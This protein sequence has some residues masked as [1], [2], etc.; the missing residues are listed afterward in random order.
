MISPYTRPSSLNPSREVS[1][2]PGN[3]FHTQETFSQ[4][5]PPFTPQEDAIASFVNEEVGEMKK[6]TAFKA[7]ALGANEVRNNVARELSRTGGLR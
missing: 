3:L 4:A 5:M 6:S 7:A 1:K 2:P